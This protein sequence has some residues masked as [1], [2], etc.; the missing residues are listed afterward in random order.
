M[1]RQL[2]DY[3]HKKLRSAARSGMDAMILPLTLESVQKVKTMKE[4]TAAQ[5]TTLI[6]LSTFMNT[7][8][9]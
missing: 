4:K 3:I 7:N 8:K 2:D 6:N 9:E 5:G 1:S